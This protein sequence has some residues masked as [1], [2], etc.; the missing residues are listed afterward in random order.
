MVIE[1]KD[2]YLTLINPSLVQQ[3]RVQMVNVVDPLQTGFPV[4]SRRIL[5]EFATGPYLARLADS[6]ITD[7]R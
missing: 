6:Y 7:L 2:N 1:H 5:N 4:I 3:G